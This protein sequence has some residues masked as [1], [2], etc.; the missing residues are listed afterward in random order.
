[1]EA[2]KAKLVAAPR[3]HLPHAHSHRGGAH[4]VAVAAEEGG[5][6]GK[7]INNNFSQMAKINDAASP[8][9]GPH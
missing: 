4:A 5:G 6:P 8:R 7:H 9:L 1:M 2:A 3:L